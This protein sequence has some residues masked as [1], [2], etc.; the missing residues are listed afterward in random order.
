MLNLIRNLSLVVSAPALTACTLLAITGCAGG[1]APP[2]ATSQAAS[3]P[4]QSVRAPQ[5]TGGTPKKIYIT[6]GANNTLTTYEYDGTQTTPT[7]TDSLNDPQGV[8]VDRHGKIYVAN[9]ASG[10]VTTYDGF[11]N[12]TT[13]TISVTA[14]TAV[15]VD[16]NGKIYVGAANSLT[17]YNRFGKQTKPTIK[18]G[19]RSLNVIDDVTVDARGKIYLTSS[20]G[21]R[22]FAWNLHGCVYGCYGWASFVTTYNPDGSQVTPTIELEIRPEFG[23]VAVGGPAVDAKGKIYVVNTYFDNLRT[24]T[25]AG[26]RTK[27]SI[28]RLSSPTGVAVDANGKIYVT[29]QGNNTLTTYTRDGSPT[30]PTISGLDDPTGVALH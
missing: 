8:A 1:A 28:G 27:P 13:P 7:I 17:T 4:L 24:Y 16:T 5:R 22:I 29:N 20:Y 2:V 6:N 11:G 23:M 30:T 21:R 26:S 19:L 10:L 14:A 9:A 18:I 15:A 3:L 25:A 12:R